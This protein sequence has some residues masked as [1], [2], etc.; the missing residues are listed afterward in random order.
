MAKAADAKHSHKITRF[1]RRVSQ[2]VERR[3]PRAQQRRRIGR[4][5]AVGNRHESVRLCDHHLG[6]SPI[7]MNAREFLVTTVH[8]IAISTEF[9]ITAR[10]SEEA[11]THALTN[12]PALDTGAKGIDSPD[13]FMAWHARPAK[14]KEAFHRARIRMANAAGL[15]TDSNLS[16][17]WLGN[18]FL[19]D[20]QFPRFCHL[21][22][23]ILCTH[24]YSLTLV[25]A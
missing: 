16:R 18:R 1:R 25:I 22:R 4:R 6:I 13:R 20:F 12:R 8:E 10:P 9:A 7:R 19:N 21:Y 14:R 24:K 15:D 11:N 23:F 17:S 3:K 2:C 5:E